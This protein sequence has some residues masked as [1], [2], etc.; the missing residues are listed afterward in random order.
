MAGKV[1]V[2]LGLAVVAAAIVAFVLVTLEERDY[3]ALLPAPDTILW[4]EGDEATLWLDTNRRDVDV[5]ISGVSLGVGDIERQSADGTAIT[6]GRGIGCQ[7]WVVSR[8]Y[9]EQHRL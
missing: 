5:R 9:R 8:L 6:L 4:D 7:D 1:G 3:A 2:P